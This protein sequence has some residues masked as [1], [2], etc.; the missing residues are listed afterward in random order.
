VKV[1][2]TIG[3]DRAGTKALV[4]AGVEGA[5]NVEFLPG[6]GRG[7]AARSAVVERA[8]CRALNPLRQLC[9]AATSPCRGGFNFTRQGPDR[10]CD[11]RPQLGLVRAE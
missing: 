8:W 10:R 5:R 2:N 6:T 9:R 1:E 7:T 11:P 4:P 3:L